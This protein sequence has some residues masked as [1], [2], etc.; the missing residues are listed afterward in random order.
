MTPKMQPIIPRAPTSFRQSDPTPKSTIYDTPYL[1]SSNSS[2]E[3]IYQPTVSKPSYSIGTNDVPC[4]KTYLPSLRDPLLG[5]NRGIDGELN[6]SYIDV[7]IF[8]MFAYSDVFDSFL[9]MKVNDKSAELQRILKDNIVHVLRDSDGFVSRRFMPLVS[10]CR[11]DLPLR[12]RGCDAS[13]YS[14]V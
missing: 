9:T 14:S 8:S 7:I 13:F 12:F 2:R 5:E 11:I 10:F 3:N 1:F 4:I 6:S